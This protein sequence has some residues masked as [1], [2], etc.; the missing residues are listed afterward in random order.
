V[1][2]DFSCM[3]CY[4]LGERALTKFCWLY[5]GKVID[6]DI[7]RGLFEILIDV[8]VLHAA[9]DEVQKDAPWIDEFSRWCTVRGSKVNFDRASYVDSLTNASGGRLNRGVLEAKFA[10]LRERIS[11]D[12]RGFINGHDFVQ[13][14][15]WFAHQIGVSRAIYDQKPLHRALMTSIELDELSAMPLFDKL[16]RWAQST[17]SKDGVT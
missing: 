12:F 5:L 15:S 10:E 11:G 3:E 9:K 2:T 8:F 13:L 6:A 4:A 16:T 1:L 14:V 7:W 17:D